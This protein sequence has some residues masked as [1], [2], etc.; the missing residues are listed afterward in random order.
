MNAPTVVSDE[1]RR[2][3]VVGALLFMLLAA[4]DQTIISPALP[5]IGASL[6]DVTWLPWVVSAYFLTGTAVTPLYGKLAD[7][8]GRRSVLYAAVAIFLVGSVLCALAPSMFWLVL[9]RAVQ[10]LGGGG[11]I[12]LA[13]TIIGDAVPPRDRAKYMVYISGMW[14]LA[15][16]AGPM[17]GGVFA[18]HVHWSLIFWIN[19]PLGIAAIVISDRTLRKMPQVRRKHALDLTGAALI[20]A[21]TVAL[22]LA[23]TWG[24][25]TYGWSSSVIM[26]LLVGSTALFAV[27]AWHLTR[28][29]EPLIP[30]R[31]LANP[32][33]AAATASMFFSMASSVGLTVY[34]PVYL[35]LV[36]GLGPASA[37]FALVA[38]MAGTVF[39]ASV[40][41]RF[42][43]KG[44]NYKRIAMWGGVVSVVG[45]LVLAAVATSAPFFVIEI[46][47]AVIGFGTGTQFPVTT[48][49]VQNAAEQRDLGVA[50]STLSFMRSLG[51]VIGVAV[52]GS[53]LIST[54]VVERVGEGVGSL[55]DPA[56]GLHA[57]EV[58]RW[59]FA[60]AALAQ[61]IALVLLAF[62]AERPLQAQRA[63]EPQPE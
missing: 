13:Q 18:Q 3:I 30:L 34:V 16:L 53:I 8:R 4:L 63:V 57:A 14:A 47:T 51:S 32:V 27:F 50:T 42:M 40:A 29:V 49:A 28:A 11:L 54:G 9:G 25:V 2:A 26:G 52:L 24:G 19:L 46:L 62:M 48:V 21:A 33:I 12:A 22:Q 10:G 1:E 31:V 61:V 44:T 59:V 43:R 39:G 5:T 58:F 20:V 56:A 7:L 23:L 17:I 60:V 36:V 15:S 35:Q 38:L 55:V 37:G 45:L 41:G 6:G